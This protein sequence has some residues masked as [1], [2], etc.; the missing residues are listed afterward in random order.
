MAKTDTKQRRTQGAKTGWEIRRQK[1]EAEIQRRITAAVA[2]RVTIEVGSFQEAWK[3]EKERADALA[4]ALHGQ[5]DSNNRL[6]YQIVDLRASLA[7]ARAVARAAF[8]FILSS[9]VQPGFGG[10]ASWL[11][12]IEEEGDAPP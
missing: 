2:E 3:G 9:G 10:D 7:Q 5:G 11:T 8:R 12:R 4:E 6:Q 1:Q